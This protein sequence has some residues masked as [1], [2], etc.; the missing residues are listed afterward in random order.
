MSE[1]NEINSLKL[2]VIKALSTLS[3][4]KMGKY[5]SIKNMSVDLPLSPKVFAEKFPIQ[6]N[7][8]E[9]FKAVL[10][11]L[12]LNSIF[13]LNWHKVNFNNSTMRKRIIGLIHIHYR[14]KILPMNVQFEPR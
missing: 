8:D 5:T 6:Y 10:A 7:Y 14:K 3:Y 9:N 1:F 13:G 4:C 12:D 11:V 2:A